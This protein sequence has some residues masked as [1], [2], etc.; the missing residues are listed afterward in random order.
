MSNLISAVT[1]VKRGVSAQHPQ[2]Y[3]L[4][5]QELERVSA[6]AR[7]ELED[8][9]VELERAHQAAKKMERKETETEK[10]NRDDDDD[11]DDDDDNWVECVI[12]LG[13]KATEL[14]G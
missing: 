12:K 1:W 7:I 8:A 11:D 2:K 4:D 10:D 3:V 6:L 5:N 13:G 14:I 9:K